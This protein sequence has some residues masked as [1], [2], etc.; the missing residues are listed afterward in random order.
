MILL[1]TPK[2]PVAIYL[3]DALPVLIY[4][5]GNHVASQF[6]RTVKIFTEMK[7]KAS[8]SSKIYYKLVRTPVITSTLN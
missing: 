4:L 8:S 2:L 6:S 1:V 7:G 5:E 3:W